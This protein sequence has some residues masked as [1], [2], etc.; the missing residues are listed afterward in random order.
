MGQNL[1]ILFHRPACP[2]MCCSQPDLA[3]CCCSCCQPLLSQSSRWYRAHAVLQPPSSCM[4]AA[5]GGCSEE[6]ISGAGSMWCTGR[7]GSAGGCPALK[8]PGMCWYG[9][10]CSS[11]E[12]DAVGA[13]LCWRRSQAG[14][15]PWAGAEAGFISPMGAMAAV[16]VRLFARGC[17]AG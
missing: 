11:G 17:C 6:Q 13:W 5:T 3:V 7:P 2:G 15:C 16:D 8:V 12:L 14:C 4:A 10:D 9:S 1:P